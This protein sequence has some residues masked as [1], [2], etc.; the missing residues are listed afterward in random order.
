MP[1]TLLVDCR[2]RIAVLIIGLCCLCAGDQAWAADFTDSGPLRIRDQFLPGMGLLA[3]EPQ[4]AAALPA[5]DSRI[6]MIATVSN[7][8][9]MSE[10]LGNHLEDRDRRS[11]LSLA[12]LR[13]IGSDSMFYLDGEVYR[14]ALALDFGVTARMEI[15]LTLQW[16]SFSG[17]AF[18]GVIEGVHDVFSFSQSGR[19][20]VPRDRFTTYLR[21]KDLEYHAAISAGGGLGDTV[22]RAKYQLNSHG[23]N[24]NLAVQ[25]LVKLPTWNGHDFFSSGSTDV[26]I[27]L[28]G[29]HAPLP[30]L[31]L[32]YALG[33]LRLGD[34]PLLE[35]PSQPLWSGTTAVEIDTSD[36]ST[37]IAQLTASQSPFTELDLPELG[38]VSLQVSLGYKR[39]LATGLSLFIALTEN[40]AHFDN[41]ADVGMHV[42]LSM[43]ASP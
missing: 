22:M 13:E 24:W 11:S 38:Q 10:V 9:A 35:L 30:R 26:G 43:Q 20:G 2:S 39:E 7:T 36:R 18:D 31:R 21:S 4:S 16:L 14:L 42:G 23:D 37:W 32:H 12:D 1:F 34:W 29:S 33:L 28:L 40:I 41:S 19:T 15:G 27:Q 5:G 8:F 25:G 17:G 3:F 6:E